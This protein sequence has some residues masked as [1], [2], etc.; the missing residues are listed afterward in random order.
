[1]GDIIWFKYCSQPLRQI[2][3]SRLSHQNFHCPPLIPRLMLK[4]RWG[5]P[6]PHMHPY[7]N[8]TYLTG[9]NIKIPTVSISRLMLKH[10]GINPSGRCILTMTYLTG[11]SIKTPLSPQIYMLGSTLAAN[12][13]SNDISSRLLH[14]NPHRLPLN[15]STI[16]ENMLGS[17]LA[18][19][20]PQ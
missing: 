8:M 14:Q 15:P 4:T 1:M 11:F 17:T 9:F 19:N 2:H 7:N 20:A 6:L 16:A 13:F 3:P 18:A 12:P 10:A 5:Q